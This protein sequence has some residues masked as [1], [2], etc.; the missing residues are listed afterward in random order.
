M[1]DGIIDGIQLMTHVFNWKTAIPNGLTVDKVRSNTKQFYSKVGVN[2]L[3][4][5]AVAEKRIR[6]DV[7]KQIFA[8][9]DIWSHVEIHIGI[10]A[11]PIS[12]KIESLKNDLFLGAS[13]VAPD[14]YAISSG[15]ETKC[16][17]SDVN[18]TQVRKLS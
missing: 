4:I 11:I 18:S 17:P 16:Q 9:K 6:C 7:C 1:L 5:I 3:S 8:E 10:L 14:D 2:S 13:K 15:G 12:D